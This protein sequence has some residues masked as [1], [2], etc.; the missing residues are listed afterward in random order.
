[1][2][3]VEETYSKLQLENQGILETRWSHVNVLN[4]AEPCGVK[5]HT[6]CPVYFT[7]IKKKVDSPPPPPG[8]FRQVVHL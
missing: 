8:F 5:W 3:D 6:G 1:M 2:G 7:T 4:A